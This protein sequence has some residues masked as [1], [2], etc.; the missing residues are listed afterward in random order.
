MSSSSATVVNKNKSSVS[1][2]VGGSGDDDNGNN[3]TTTTTTRR[4][5]AATAT[6]ALEVT[7]SDID[8]EM[9][10]D[11]NNI[12]SATVA[13][14][15]V[16]VDNSAN[17]NNNSID[18]FDFDTPE[19]F[20]LYHS[21][22]GNLKVVEKLIL[23]AKK[24]EIDLDLNCKGKQKS[25][26]GWSPLHLAAYFGHLNV[27]DELLNNNC[28]V[29]IV[30][31]SGDTALHKAAYT[32]RED[33]C[34][35]LVAANADVLIINGDGLTPRE[36]A[37]KE[38]V[39]RIL[40]AAEEADVKRREERFLSAARN[41]D[42]DTM[43]SLLADTSKPLDINCKDLSGN[44]ALHCS[45]YRAQKEVAVFLLKHGIDVAVKNNRGQLASALAPNVQIKQLLHEVQPLNAQ[46]AA[47]KPKSV[48]RF[49]G[50]LLKKGRFLG[51][52]LI[53]AVLERGVFSFFARRADA[54]TGTRRKGYRYLESAICEPCL[55]G[56]PQ[57]ETKF[58]IYF[59]DRSRVLLSVPSG[60]EAVL[61]SPV[62]VER[63]K[64]LN[65]INDHIYYGTNFIKQGMRYDCDS[66]DEELQDLVPNT[67]IQTLIQTANAHQSILE[68]H[69][70]AML[71]LNDDIVATERQLSQCNG[72]GGG[73]SGAGGVC[74]GDTSIN[75]CDQSFNDSYNRLDTSAAAVSLYSDLIATTLPSIKFHVNLILESSANATGALSQCLTVLTHQDEVR[76]M[77]LKQEQEKVRVLEDALH[78]LAREHHDLEQSLATSV[79][80]GGGI[81]SGG[82]GNNNNHQSF[83]TCYHS[84]PARSQSLCGMSDTTTI[85]GDVD[86]F[87]DAFD[88]YPDDQLSEKTITLSINGGADDADDI[89]DR[90]P[91][92]ESYATTTV[93]SDYMT[94]VASMADICAELPSD[95]QYRDR[96][97]SVMV[98]REEVSLWSILKHCIGKELSKITFPV[99]FNEPLSFLQRM[100]E[101][102]EYA[103]LLNEADQLDDPIERMEY[104]CAFIVS[105]Y[106]SNWLRLNKPFNPLLGETYEYDLPE[107]GL[108]VLFEQVSHHPPI[109]AWHA[110]SDHFILHGTINPKLKFWGKSIEVSPEGTITLK[111]KNKPDVYTWKSVNC[112]VHNIIVGKLWFEQYGLMEV[113]NQ[114]NGM[115]TQLNFKP[116]GWFG[117]D[118]HRFDGF[119]NSPNKDKLRFVYG[120]WADYFKTAGADEY[121]EY[122][123]INANKFRVPDRP[124]GE[125]PSTPRKVFSKLNSLTR[126]LTGGGGGGSQS[127]SSSD[128]TPD[129]GSGN[130]N[131]NNSS[132][133]TGGQQ[134]T[135]ENGVSNG[136]G[137]G[138]IPKSD[139]SHSLDIPNSRL[140]W[141]AIARPEHS[142]QYYHYT[143]FSMSLNQLLDDHRRG[144]KRLPPTDSRYRP[145]VRKLEDGDLDSAA[146]E[147][148]RLEEKQRE[149]R[150]QRKKSKQVWQPLWFKAEQNKY[151]KEDDWIYTG[152]YW[153]RDWSRCPE[154]Y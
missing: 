67:G 36:L 72:S 96:L 109:S 51:W 61:S 30:N 142:A 37:R 16:G 31:E 116:A 115:R 3:T 43:R 2:V 140:L 138:E 105:S 18:G 17:N 114:S 14:D 39:K 111:L 135:A 44:T 63:Q 29:N 42:I 12:S 117:K 130:T 7:D 139:S 107:L 57:E 141:Q 64:W 125:Q 78:V 55:D 90:T 32:G 25:N 144:S 76:Q 101:T 99:V 75:S 120:K 87:F 119:I 102:L 151:T 104:V 80:V 13:S 41:G 74:A 154:I 121:D 89:N 45:A 24:S 94:P 23:L 124:A 46:L 68:R 146:V 84:P 136:G 81:G 95:G 34:V 6:A 77:L 62:T 148:N 118:L 1:V 145:D 100:T 91:A 113:V 123:R 56:G 4:A 106:S 88:D 149:V 69:I 48:G 60:G 110:E 98:P 152:H 131:N 65:A 58:V 92:L 93:T 153:E 40:L 134:Q 28:D 127:M 54:S 11:N 53:W 132:A 108:R 143:L 47:L 20:L 83:G 66:D 59:S 133:A 10:K 35:R 122:M 79:S 19:E 129:N 22:T 82:G 70:R 15:A 71:Q 50:P 52:R 150:R 9:A 49:E 86:E 97:P 147:K 8:D 27:V 112:C 103:H 85:G 73:G 128:D 26:Y 5:S 137:G 33:I 38:S 21:R 126:Q